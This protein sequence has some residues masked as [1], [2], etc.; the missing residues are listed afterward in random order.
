MRRSSPALIAAVT[1]AAAAAPGQAS[2]Q[3]DD[4]PADPSFSASLKLDGAIIGAALVA[5]GLA[6][7][8]PV[9][10]AARWERELL[11]LDQP[12]RR[13]FSDTAARTSDVLVTAAVLTPLCLQAGQGFNATTGRRSLIYGE[14]IAVSLA[15]NAV[16]K[17]LVARPRPYVYNPYPRVQAYARAEEVDGHLSFY[18]G[19]AATAFAAAV[20]G[21]YLFA[22]GTDDTNARTAVWATGLLLAGA[23]SNLRVRAGKHFPS[24]VAVGA[25]AGAAAGLAIPLLHP[26]GGSNQLAASEW[27]AIAAA[28]VAGA[29]LSQM[30]PMAAD[31]TEPLAGKQAG[32]VLPWISDHGAGLTLVRTF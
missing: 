8:I 14:T 25:A 21:A 23:A 12:A 18:S 1:L 6:R 4:A 27:I 28:P 20:G 9:D 19:H 30:L 22:Q 3:P 31:I 32:L 13:N 11:P 5:I 10:T 29:L 17:Y 2:A 7:L 15:L 26:R 16:A 24:D